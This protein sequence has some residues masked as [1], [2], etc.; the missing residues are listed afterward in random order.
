M[1]QKIGKE[2]KT[3]DVKREK[4]RKRDKARNT[5]KLIRAMFAE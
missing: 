1:K 2:Y 5:K 4:C 3:R